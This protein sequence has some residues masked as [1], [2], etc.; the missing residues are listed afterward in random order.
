[1][2]LSNHLL[3]AIFAKFLQRLKARRRG[4]LDSRHAVSKLP[5]VF[6]LFSK[7]MGRDQ[8]KL[9]TDQEQDDNENTEPNT[10]G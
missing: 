5:H 10:N 8:S 1:M 4:F 2:I 6:P 3:F 7:P 9:G